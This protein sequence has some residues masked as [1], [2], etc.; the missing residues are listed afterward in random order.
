MKTLELNQM[1]KISGS[2]HCSAATFFS[3]L[4]MASGGTNGA[5]IFGAFG[6][7]QTVMCSVYGDEDT[8]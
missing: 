1:E 3:V 8:F 5:S 2:G 7:Y 4:S 6:L